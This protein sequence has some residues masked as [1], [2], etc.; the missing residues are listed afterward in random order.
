MYEAVRTTA[1]PAMIWTIVVVMTIF[2]AI[3]VAA[4][5]VADSMQR[6][7]VRRIRMT[8]LATGPALG[9]GGTTPDAAVGAG[10]P[11]AAG[12]PSQRA[13]RETATGQPD[14]RQREAVP[15]DMAAA[16]TSRT[17]PA[18]PVP[19]QRRDT[20]P[21]PGAAAGQPPVPDATEAP[22][23]PIPATRDAVAG[24]R[25]RSVPAPGPRAEQGPVPQQGPSVEPGPMAEQGPLPQNAAARGRHARGGAQPAQDAAA[26]GSAASPEG[27][28]RAGDAGRHAMPAQR[29]GESDRAERSFAG[30]ANSDPDDPDPDPDQGQPGQP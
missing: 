27:P 1:S 22:T 17:D 28:A 18:N 20:A 24:G 6:R 4:P 21:Q 2:T 25:Q 13:S 23:E 14:S 26:P 8:L 19:A 30:P 9:A 16:S 3:L 7:E 11:A 12:L 10:P 29:G 5:A 15:P